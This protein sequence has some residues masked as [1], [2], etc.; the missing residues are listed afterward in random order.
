MQSGTKRKKCSKDKRDRKQPKAGDEGAPITAKAS[1]AAD[2]AALPESEATMEEQ[3]LKLHREL[4][5]RARS[6]KE[7]ESTSADGSSVCLRLDD[8]TLPSFFDYYPHC[9]KIAETRYKE[10]N[11]APAVE[12]LKG[13]MQLLTTGCKQG[14]EA[15]MGEDGVI[16][17]SD[18][19]AE[20]EQ[21]TWQMDGGPD[22][23]LPFVPEAQHAVEAAFAADKQSLQL[24][25]MYGQYHVSLEQMTQQ[26]IQSGTVRRIRRV[27]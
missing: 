14:M 15:S 3:Y 25:T 17:L 2:V 18:A 11:T 1:T 13:G 22:G 16:D 26:N 5:H 27:V 12:L 7:I 8:K 10:G 19:K 21:A 9:R 23:W 6:V 24:A 4:A 20:A